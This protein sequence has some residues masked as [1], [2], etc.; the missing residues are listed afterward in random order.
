M[1]DIGLPAIAVGD[2]SP[3][4]D[5]SADV[6]PCFEGPEKVLE[7]WFVPPS[8]YEESNDQN[9]SSSEAKSAD[10]STSQRRYL[11]SV[12]RSE[13]ESMLDLVHCQILR[14]VYCASSPFSCLL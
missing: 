12:P 2:A 14:Y 4:S 11:L 6:P 3:A 13:W 1:S 8:E 7:L 9:G 10:G 5:D